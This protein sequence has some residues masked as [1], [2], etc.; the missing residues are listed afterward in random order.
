MSLM[1]ENRQIFP[2]SNREFAFYWIFV[3]SHT[4]S[5]GR[6]SWKSFGEL[7]R[8]LERFLTVPLSKAL[9]FALL[10]FY[11]FGILLLLLSLHRFT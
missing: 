5:I 10:A 2:M 6:T 7:K 1:I 8:K 11:Q 9:K 4:Y 3:S